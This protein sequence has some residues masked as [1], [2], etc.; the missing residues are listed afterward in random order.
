MMT[1]TPTPLLVPLVVDAFACTYPVLSQKFVTVRSWK[2]HPS[3]TNGPRE[4][5]VP[6]ALGGEETD[7]KDPERVGV[8]VHWRLPRALLTRAHL[9]D[10]SG[11]APDA[12]QPDLR[13]YRLVPNRWLVIRYARPT[14]QPPTGTTA[15]GWIIH[16]D[17][18]NPDSGNSIVFPHPTTT[19]G[20]K[21]GYPK[22]PYPK[23][24]FVGRRFDLSDP[25]EVTAEKT[26]SGAAE[27]SGF[28]TALGPGLPAFAHFQ[29][30]N[31]NVFSFRDPAIDL[32][33]HHDAPHTLSYLVMGWYSTAQEDPL[34][35][36]G[37][38]LATL[39]ATLGW[40]PPPGVPLARRSVYSGTVLGLN[41][42]PYGKWKGAEMPPPPSRCPKDLS[43]IRIGL[44]D[45]V[46]ESAAALLGTTDQAPLRAVLEAFAHG[47]LL[48]S[49]EP[50]TTADHNTRLHST[51][52]RTGTDPG[53]RWAVTDRP[54][55][56]PNAPQ[57]TTAEQRILARLN[58]DQYQ[59]DTEL[60][61][62]RELLHRLHDTWLLAGR[63]PEEAAAPYRELLDPHDP[64]SLLSRTTAQYHL[65]FSTDGLRDAIPWGPTPDKFDA[66]VVAYEEKVE[67]PH[68]DH[69]HLVRTPLPAFHRPQTTALSIHGLSG[70]DDPAPPGP[71]PCRTQHDVITAIHEV[72][73]PGTSPCPTLPTTIPADVKDLIRPQVR[74]FQLLDA[75]R[76]TGPL[77]RL[78]PDQ[79]T[80][81]LPRMCGTGTSPGSHSSSAGASKPPPPLPHQRKTAL[82]L[83]DRNQPLPLERQRRLHRTARH[84]L[85]RQ[86]H[87]GP[88]LP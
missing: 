69:R 61:I 65:L 48:D 88:Q 36:A 41:W 34:A 5:D 37:K 81:H 8:F 55:T 20:I 68:R 32:F 74:E 23:A 21:Y 82:E 26:A 1:T 40:A 70:D 2:P 57:D 6:E 83:P 10:I 13:G 49:D 87:R 77:S 19:T 29:P 67:L 4:H 45:T 50:V 53:Y 79:V 33:T 80:G 52:F 62:Y 47:W 76:H 30:Y 64:D 75:A 25:A 14:G 31:T 17:D 73:D 44:G 38:D 66:A 16:S 63:P 28:L 84:R 43:D 22:V 86:T 54:D 59:Y 27:Q 46:T 35:V 15:T 39:L 71:L 72:A 24:T 18:L 58:A 12:G 42:Y 78:K 51:H 7:I 9:S 11:R 3:A 85:E 60:Q 56:P